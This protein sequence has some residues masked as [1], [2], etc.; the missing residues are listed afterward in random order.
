MVSSVYPEMV[1]QNHFRIGS[2]DLLHFESGAD[3]CRGRGHEDGGVTV[4]CSGAARLSNCVR[5][6]AFPACARAGGRGAAEF[7]RHFLETERADGQTDRG[8]HHH[9]DAAESEQTDRLAQFSAPSRPKSVDA[10][11]KRNHVE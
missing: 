11:A 1:H 4:R 6:R 2:S 5:A 10:G 7:P 8:R 9:G 3:G